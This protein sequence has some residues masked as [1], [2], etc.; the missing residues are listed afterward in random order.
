MSEA[1]SPAVTPALATTLATKLSYLA[2]AAGLL[3][4]GLTISEFVGI[5]IGLTS[6]I[7]MIYTARANAK[8]KRRAIELI[9]L[10]IKNEKSKSADRQ[11]DASGD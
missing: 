9:D 4:A 3:V 1:I 8:H 10:Q 11:D 2:S 7:T 5:A 6:I